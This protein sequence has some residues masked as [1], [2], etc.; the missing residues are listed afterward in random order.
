[1]QDQNKTKDVFYKF[2]DEN[3]PLVLP[4]MWIGYV[5]GAISFAFEIAV[6]ILILN[7]EDSFGPFTDDSWKTTTG[8]IVQGISLFATLLIIGSW[9]Y[10]LICIEKMHAI[11][12]RLNPTYPITP[13]KA[14]GYH[15]IPIY[16]VYWIFKW[17]KK[18]LNFVSQKNGQE[19]AN[20]WIAVGILLLFGKFIGAFV[21]GGLDI[22]V[23]F[24]VGVYLTRKLGTVLKNDLNKN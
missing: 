18:L 20:G 22:I 7:F 13:G 14:V 19:M 23:M 17:P 12:R 8:Q 15:F 11:I 2:R 24:S 3:V 21:S 4:K 5:A 9:I 1:M 16:N 10:W 6:G